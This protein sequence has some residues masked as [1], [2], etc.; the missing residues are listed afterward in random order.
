MNEEEWNGLIEDDD[1][2][3]NDDNSEFQAKILE[4]DKRI[5]KESNSISNFNK[6][7]RDNNEEEHEHKIIPIEK[8]N[9]LSNILTIFYIVSTFQSILPE[10]VIISSSSHINYN[11]LFTR[12]W[13]L[14]LIKKKIFK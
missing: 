1:E 7:V 5:R 8:L 6:E 4:D 11:D 14:L 3:S 2:K 10:I 13:W 9:Y 12:L